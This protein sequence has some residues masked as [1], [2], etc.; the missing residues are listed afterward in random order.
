MT[1]GIRKR[2]GSLKRDLA[3]GRVALRRS[4]TA[5][6]GWLGEGNVGDEAMFQ[7]HRQLLPGLD[8]V[9]VPASSST[10]PAR[11]A[12]SLPWLRCQAVCLGGGTLIGNGHFRLALE[13]ALAAWPRAPRFTL[14]V[15][16][17][18]PGY[19]VGLR[20]GVVE[21]L[22]RWRVLLE[23]FHS[24]GVRGP[25]SQSALADLGI[26][27]DVVGDP[28]LALRPPTRPPDDGLLGLNVGT[29]DDQ[30]GLDPAAF[31]RQAVNLARGLLGDGWR[32][33]L[34]PTFSGDVAFQHEL[35]DELGDG[36]SVAAGP[37][38]VAQ[39]AEQL[40]RC[41]VVIAHKLHAAVLAAA[42][43]VPAI[44]LEY[45]PKCRDFQESVGRGAFVMRT[46]Q[47][48]EALM[49]QWV[50]ETADDRAGHARSLAGHVGVLRERLA[51]AAASIT[52]A[53][54]T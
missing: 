22:E 32:I 25:L 16:V 51:T 26:E 29:V 40:A 27:S 4:V 35:A 37:L 6:V 50:R 42:V 8:F 18:D 54:G 9:G 31:R 30:W 23:G 14:G 5:Y 48:D 41:Q 2:A 52:A 17:E 33:L 13:N 11:I 49:R 44:A 7:A 34:V 20:S 10:A 47:M 46:D 38:G 19:R 36:V 24:V 12:G 39:V 28:A 1:N 15:G 53:S 3:F 45:R 21:E 43:E